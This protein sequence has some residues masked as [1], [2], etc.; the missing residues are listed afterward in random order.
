[1]SR[2]P[3]HILTALNEMAAD[4]YEIGPIDQRR[5]REFDTLCRFDA[6]SNTK[7][8]RLCPEP[9]EAIGHGQ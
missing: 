7:P 6:S 2:T 9:S 1:M 8:S 4:L 3:S 5:M